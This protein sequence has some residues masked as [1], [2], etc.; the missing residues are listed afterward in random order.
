MEEHNKNLQ[1][2]ETDAVGESLITKADEITKQDAVNDLE[3]ILKTKIL[4]SKIVITI[5]I[6]AIA[7]IVA[8]AVAVAIIL[9]GIGSGNLSDDRNSGET[10]GDEGGHSTHIHAFGEWSV[11]KAATCNEEG[12]YERVCSCGE[13]ETHS[14]D[15]ITIH[16]EVIDTAVDAT[17]TQT[18]LTEGK[19]CSVCNKVITEQ[20]EI[21]IIAHTYDNKY[22]AEC[23]ACGHEREAECAHTETEVISA[24]AATCTQTGLTEGKRCSNCNEI[25]IEQAEI[26]IISHTYDNKYDAECNVCGHERE[27]ECAHTETEVISAVTATC[28]QTGLTEGKK[29]KKCGHILVAQ[30]TIPVQHEYYYTYDEYCHAQRCEKCDYEGTQENHTRGLYGNCLV[31]DAAMTIKEI[32]ANSEHYNGMYVSF[33]GVVVENYNNSAYVEEYD[34][35][36]GIYFGIQVYYGFNLDGFGLN[37]L[38]VGN[39]VRIVGLLQFYEAGGTYQISDLR[40]RRYYPDDPR[41]IRLISEGNSASYQ[42]VS[43]QTLLNGTVDVT[44]IDYESREKV[45]ETLDY[46]FLTM[47]SSKTLENLTIVRTFTTNAG[48]ITS[49]SNGAITLTCVDENGNEI[50]LRTTVMYNDDGSL[51]TADSFPIGA[52]IA[53]AKGIVDY[54]RDS[55]QLKIFNFSDIILY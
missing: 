54:Y 12:V 39:K 23:N 10:D 18:G 42:K 32:L 11:V 4:T 35:E 47:G 14:I 16:T 31:C 34:E 27:A 6:S 30:E 33:E 38:S 26:P 17:C 53:S 7:V 25:I 13:V 29:C 5:V 44:V 40:Y 9:G 1:N 8:I 50:L 21:P 41:N 55:Y 45:T 24:I 46:G 36:T 52:K 49:G 15:K 48:T 19:H 37:I 3:P 28:T 43:T 20:V 22:D 51:V 2:H